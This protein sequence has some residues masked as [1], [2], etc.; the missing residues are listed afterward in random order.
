[1]L[2]TVHT[3]NTKKDIITASC[4]RYTVIVERTNYW[5]HPG[6]GDARGRSGVLVRKGVHRDVRELALDAVCHSVDG[7]Q[8]WT[9]WAAF[10]IDDGLLRW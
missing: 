7:T 8:Q 9:H 10:R 4:T 2:E 5:T 1:M 3:C 6:L